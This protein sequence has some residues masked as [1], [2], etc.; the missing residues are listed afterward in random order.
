VP[1]CSANTLTYAQ[2]ALYGYSVEQYARQQSIATKAA[3]RTAKVF[4]LYLR[5]LLEP[6]NFTSHCQLR[7]FI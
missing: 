6:M 7:Q 2:D 1:P 5:P 3:E 4:L